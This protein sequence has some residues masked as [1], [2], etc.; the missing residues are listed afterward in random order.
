MSFDKITEVYQENLDVVTSQRGGETYEW[1]INHLEAFST[2][3]LADILTL[4]EVFED[5]F[6][7]DFIDAIEDEL[8]KRIDFIN[9]ND[10]I[11][12]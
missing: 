3:K 10:Y 1:T 11:V 2:K 5:L 4:S 7:D 6:K 8:I 9:T 12:H